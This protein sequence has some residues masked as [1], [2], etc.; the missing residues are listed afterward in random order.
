MKII[1]N[2]KLIQNFS[3][4]MATQSLQPTPHTQLIQELNPEVIDDIRDF[5]NT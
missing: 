4:N 3:V 2:F 5:V 1:V